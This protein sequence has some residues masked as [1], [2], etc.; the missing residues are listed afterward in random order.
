MPCVPRREQIVAPLYIKSLL[1][2][3]EP[4][5][6]D[7][8]AEADDLAGDET[9]EFVGRRRAHRNEALTHDEFLAHVGLVQVPRS[10]WSLSTIAR[11]V[12]AGATSMN[13]EGAL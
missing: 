11:G 12:L 2:T 13:Q 3:R 5:F 10:P 9:P 6:P 8:V 4:G 7:D 1:R